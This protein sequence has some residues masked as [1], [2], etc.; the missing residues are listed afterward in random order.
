MQTDM[1]SVGPIVIGLVG[2]LALFLFG[3][4][5]MTRALKTVAGAGMKTMLARLTTNRFKAILAGAGITA[6]IQ[7][8]SVTTVLVVGF[9]SAGLMNLSQ[10][11]GIILGADIGTTIT[12][13]IIAFKITHYALVLVAVG[14]V[15]L[16][17]MKNE[18][19]KQYGT[20]IFGLGLVFLGMNLMSEA[21]SPLRSYV[22]FISLM[23]S[24]SN[25]LSG[26]L[27]GALFTALVQSSSASI[28]VIIVL[29]SQGFISLDAGIALT[30]GANI[31]TCITAMLASIGKPREAVQ[32]GLIHV[33]FKI[34]G[35]ALWFFFIPQFADLV[36]AIS[37]QATHLEGTARLALETPRQIANAHTLF[38]VVNTLVFVG[39][40]TPIV[41]LVQFLV[42]EHQTASSV[43]Q[44]Y[45][46][47]VLLQ[48]PDLAFDLVRMELGRQGTAV[49]KMVHQVHSTVITGTSED[50]NQLQKMDNEV[51]LLHGALVTY[52]GRLSQE[53]LTQQQSERLHDYMSA[54]NYLENI[55]DIIETN[56]VDVGQNRI[57]KN[58]QI[59][60]ATQDVFRPL[61]DKVTWAVEKSIEALVSAERTKAEEVENAKEII[62]TLAETAE[63]HLAMR[64]TANEPERLAIFKLESEI[65]EYLKRV[66][67]FAK[68][69]AKVT[70]EID[71]AYN[72]P[73][74][75]DTTI[76]A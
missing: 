62:N 2:G 66:Y 40:T 54:A 71:T 20:M 6:V 43:K 7:S 64:L 60:E 74:E 1:L 12:A 53:N 42:P 51:D 21:A 72:R 18:K 49:V 26:I 33:L 58:I 45:L 59:S 34:I 22:P 36:R 29:A 9:I 38:N 28:G 10:G 56:L 16:F 44:T 15:L 50:L 32:A 3:M 57:D 76:L 13:Q 5:Q 48:T 70:I 52:L 25:P 23:Q 17:W 27:I 67:Y 63:R 14:F 46:N 35:V 8:S 31:G 68:R 75:K 55:G 37:P 30:F 24:M 11:V 4:E 69:I 61:T 19:I 39:F 41:K 65:V 73:L 47:P